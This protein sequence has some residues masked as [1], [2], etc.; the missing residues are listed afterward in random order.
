VT[1]DKDERRLGQIRSDI[2]RVQTTLEAHGH[3]A[4]F[5]DADVQDAVIM[6]LY[7]ISDLTSRLSDALRDRHPEIN[8]REIR[9]ARNVMAHAYTNLELPTLMYVT[10]RLHLSRRRPR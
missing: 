9:G 5:V 2:E 7:R 8:W 1:E 3:D 10:S 4:F 6:R